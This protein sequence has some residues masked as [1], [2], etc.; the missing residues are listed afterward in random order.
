MES[1]RGHVGA[2]YSDDNNWTDISVLAIDGV[3]HKVYAMLSQI[4]F[5]CVNVYE[6]MKRI[7]YIYT[8]ITHH[9]LTSLAVAYR[10]SA[11]PVGM[12]STPPNR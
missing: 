12:L 3:V 5:F 4:I 7:V 10:T 2:R 1:D 8:Y 9:R 11:N 6:Y